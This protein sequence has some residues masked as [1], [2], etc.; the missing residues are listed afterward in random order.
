EIQGWI[1]GDIE[2][3]Y[4]QVLV[5]PDDR[6]L[7]RILW[8]RST[9]EEPTAYD[10]RTVKY[11]TAAAPFLAIR[12]LQQVAYDYSD[13]YPDVASAISKKFY[14]DDF[15]ACAPTSVGT[16]KLKNDVCSVLSEAGFKLR[17]WSSNSRRF[18]GTIDISDCEK[19]PDTI[20][21]T[22]SAV[23]TLGW[24]WETSTDSF[25]YNV[26]LEDITLNV[27]KRKVLSDIARIFDPIGWIVPIV[28]KIKICM[29]KLWL[30]GVSWDEE[31]PRELYSESY[32]YRQNINRISKLRKP[33]WL[34]FT[35][36]SIVELHG[37]SDASEVAFAAAVYIRI[38]RRDSEV[39]THLIAAKTRVAPVKQITLPR[40]E[41]CASHLLVK[42]IIKV[43]Q[44]LSFEVV[45]VVGWTDVIP[46]EQWR[47]IPSQHN[48]ADLATRGIWLA[49]LV[50]CK[51]WWQGPDV[52][53]HKSTTHTEKPSAS[54]NVSMEERKVERFFERYSKHMHLLRF[55]HNCK[56]GSS[57][58]P[59][60]ATGISTNELQHAHN[61]LVRQEQRTYFAQELPLLLK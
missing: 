21:D 43:R 27:T 54:P 31:L 26:A 10:L 14:L 24:L 30:K 58:Q 56:T 48:T 35:D 15:L 18:L 55:V 12:T 42:L 8:R 23:K 34:D 1:A 9:E 20:I 57:K 60:T 45:D 53:I 38:Q 37:F 5:H 46:A 6:P 25:K 52:L 44:S 51:I 29:Q 11:G 49:E 17:K 32:D 13:E 47:H 3:M 33:K 7:Q 40:L 59:K 2:K 61:V 28:I 19:S 16:V 50:T 41:L 36:D 4:R 22:T 39:F